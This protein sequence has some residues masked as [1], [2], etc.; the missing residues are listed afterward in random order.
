M[1]VKGIA[2]R[3]RY[4]GPTGIA[5]V[6][7]G[8]GDAPRPGV[9]HRAWGTR[10]HYLGN[11]TNP[12]VRPGTADTRSRRLLD[13]ELEVSPLDAAVQAFTTPLRPGGGAGRRHPGLCPAI[14][15]GL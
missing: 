12:A 8:R 7:G 11:T 10:P 3:S 6:V 14:R 13:L 5:T 2:R 4:E 9:T 1:R 15:A